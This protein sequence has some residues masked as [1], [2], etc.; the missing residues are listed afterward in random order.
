MKI[1]LPI[2]ILLS[3]SALYLSMIEGGITGFFNEPLW[4]AICLGITLAVSLVLTLAVEGMVKML[5]GQQVQASINQTSIVRKNYNISVPFGV[6]FFVL[7]G[8]TAFM[9]VSSL[10]DSG[11]Y[12]LLFTLVP[13]V[14]IASMFFGLLIGLVIDLYRQS[15]R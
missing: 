4:V 5:K 13:S 2:W 9:Y 1:F 15:G 10:N 12:T 6:V 14:A 7:G 11:A 8:L 3:L